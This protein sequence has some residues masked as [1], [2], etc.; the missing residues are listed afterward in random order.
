MME[1][2]DD[3]DM[4]MGG[5]PMPTS[6]GGSRRVAAGF[7]GTS[8]SPEQVR[9]NNGT[10]G[11]TCRSMV[12]VLTFFACAPVENLPGA[13]HPRTPVGLLACPASVMEAGEPLAENCQLPVCAIRI[14]NT[15]PLLLLE[16]WLFRPLDTTRLSLWIDTQIIVAVQ[17][18]FFNPL[19][20]LSY[21]LVQKEG[22]PC[23]EGPISPCE[24][25]GPDRFSPPRKR[26]K[27]FIQIFLF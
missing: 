25:L 6:M 16:L 3:M 26:R 17:G 1:D 23:G 13:Q 12:S 22:G 9:N 15:W 2:I 24:S 14:S 4:D 18:F 20:G 8:L 21:G 5:V 19:P 7:S 27:L 11:L 10:S